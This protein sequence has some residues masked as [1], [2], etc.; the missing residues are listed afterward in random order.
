MMVFDA[1]ID[2]LS[3]LMGCNR[4]SDLVSIKGNHVNLE[5]MQKAGITG[6]IFAVFVSENY[7][8]GLMLHQAMIMIDIFW[9]N[10]CKY[11]KELRPIL[12]LEDLNSLEVNSGKIGCILSIEGG[13]TLEGRLENLR[14]FYRLGVRGLTLTWNNR[15]QL[16]DGVGEADGASGIS[17]F[18]RQVIIEMN[19]LG[20]FI[21]VSHLAKQ[22][23]WDVLKVSNSPVIAS[24]SNAYTLCRHR[25]NFTDK[26]IK[27]LADK[28]GVIGVN[29]C[30]A[31]LTIQP[32]T[33]SV[34]HVVAHIRHLLMK[35][36]SDAVGIGSDFDGISSVPKGLEDISR[37]PLIV[38]GLKDRGYPESVIEKVMAGNFIRVFKQIF[39]TRA[40]S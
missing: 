30:P 13:E 34:D 39:P 37:M 40:T 4:A 20:M 15:N 17:E 10:I 29:F 7:R 6:Q 27:A 3:R 24:H 2:T 28:G 1:H 32:K 8:H 38:A 5:K 31:F 25:R 23:F 16:A 14:N 35:G 18:G 12:W 19:R 21:D 9:Q 36:G 26:Q 22:G 11:K 33:A